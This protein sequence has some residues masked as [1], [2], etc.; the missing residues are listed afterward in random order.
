MKRSIRLLILPIIF[1][2]II[3]NAAGDIYS[4]YDFVFAVVKYSGGGDWY[5]G[6]T[7][8]KNLITH[9]KQRTDLRIAPEE[10]IVGLLDDDLF[11][12]PFIYI[13]GHGNIKFSDEEVTRLKKY[14]QNGG[15]L[16]CND[17]YGLEKSF[18]REMKKVFPDKEFI[19]VP[20]SHPIYHIFYNFPEGLPKIHEHYSGSPK[21]MGIFYQNKLVAFFSYNADIG[22]GWEKKEV[23]ND[24]EE[25]RE[26]AVRMGINIVF[27]SL[28]N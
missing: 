25:K 4:E 3:T 15:F 18:K 27:Y 26:N 16:F 9:I 13:N 8:V 2:F 24:P 22:D 11:L 1:F 28:M 12:Y 20:F 17:D 23:F 7:G 5:N 10:K 19:E 14:L 6:I 21:G